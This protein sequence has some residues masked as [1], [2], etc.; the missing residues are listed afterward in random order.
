MR[1]RIDPKIPSSRGIDV[2]PTTHFRARQPK[3]DTGLRGPG[4]A[5]DRRDPS[6]AHARPAGRLG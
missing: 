1:S 6:A 2:V 5:P 3:E 4:Q